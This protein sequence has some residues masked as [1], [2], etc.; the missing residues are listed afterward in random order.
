MMHDSFW[1][2]WVW[3]DQFTALLRHGTIY[4]RWLPLSHGGLGSPVFYYYPPLAFY[5]S[6]L[7]GLLGLSTYASI[8]ATFGA[9]LLASGYAM[10]AWLK[11]TARAPLAGALLFMAAPY[12]LFDFYGRGA[13]AE[14]LAIAFIP[15]IALGI[16]RAAEGRIGLLAVAYAGMILTHLPLALLASLFLIAPYGLWLAGRSPTKFGR[17]ALPLLLG[18]ALAAIYLVPA[19][20]LDRYRDTAQLWAQP[21]LHAASW[22][23]VWP[24][25]GV[26]FIVT[27]ILLALAP[28]IALLVF[29]GRRLLAGYAALCCFLAGGFLPGFWTL[30]GIES[31][32][33]PFR[34][35]PLAEFA[36]ATGLAQL[37]WSRPLLAVLASPALALS[38]MFA[39]L[40]PRH[41]DLRIPHLAA[42]HPDVPENL[43]RGPRDY[44]WPSHW[45]LDLSRNP[46][47]RAG[48]YTVEPRFYFPA[49]E[50]VCAGR[51][52]PARPDPATKLLSYVGQG[53]ETRL[54][55]TWAEKIGTLISLLA[56]LLMVGLAVRSSRRATKQ[57]LMEG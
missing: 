9:G 53:C 7:F 45:A 6:G 44:S 16:R 29:T 1:I 33:F 31:V 5:V 27:S 4:P 25:H 11:D 38:I 48:A 10:F 26:M 20:A 22:Q 3:A 51:R 18:L 8:I 15:L 50:V 17:I 42:S 41:P 47:R 36:I 55:F 34:M 14:Y 12:H 39:L 46:P 54:G 56:A 40:Y 37:R 23:L 43:P 49:W 32:Q 2:D 30:P 28:L 19:F 57:P 35:F 13:Q 24:A 52:V 21:R